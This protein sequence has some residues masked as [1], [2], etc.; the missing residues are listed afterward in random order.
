MLFPLLFVDVAGQQGPA[1]DIGTFVL[2]VR[3]S[4]LL[5]QDTLK[6]PQQTV[7]HRDERRRWTNAD[8]SPEGVVDWY[9]SIDVA[10]RSANSLLGSSGE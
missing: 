8:R 3:T 2:S 10:R 7:T 9:S 1:P 6:N 4:G 5:T